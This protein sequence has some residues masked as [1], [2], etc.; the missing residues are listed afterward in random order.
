SG[1]GSSEAN[2][3]QLDALEEILNIKLIERLREKESGVYSPSVRIS[4]SKIPDSRY[5]ATVS[6]GCAPENVE[7]L[8]AAALEEI[9]TIKKNGAEAGDIQKFAAEESRSTELQLKSNGF[10]LGQIAKSYQYQQNPAD[11]LEHVKNLNQITVA[12]TKTTANQFLSGDNLIRF[13][14][15][16]EKK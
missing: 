10:W 8:I 9:A 1:S 15:L 12:S 13:I 4:Y 11:V 7:K 5:N 2:N 6:F 3:L 16:P 14:L